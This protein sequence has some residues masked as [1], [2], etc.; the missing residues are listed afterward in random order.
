[1]YPRKVLNEFKQGAESWSPGRASH[2]QLRED[3]QVAKKKRV[4]FDSD[5][6]RKVP[7]NTRKSKTARA[8][9]KSQSSKTDDESDEEGPSG[10]FQQT[11]SCSL[12]EVR[13]AVK[14]LQECHRDKVRTTGFGCVFDWV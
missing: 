6:A 9:K 11:V 2:G 5:C 7:A 13:E 12:G 14:L 8:N 10:R 4:R 3:Q 1:M